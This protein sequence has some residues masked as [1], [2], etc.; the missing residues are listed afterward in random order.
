LITAAPWT[1]AFEVKPNSA[2]LLSSPYPWRLLAPL[3][4][5]RYGLQSNRYQARD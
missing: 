3:V 2:A 5:L 4:I 1:G